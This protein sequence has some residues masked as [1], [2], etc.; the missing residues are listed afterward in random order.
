MVPSH[1]L[2]MKIGCIQFEQLFTFF[3]LQTTFER[4]VG[5]RLPPK[6]TAMRRDQVCISQKQDVIKHP[7]T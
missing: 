5:Q 4:V 7:P 1:P 2:V 6:I 3:S